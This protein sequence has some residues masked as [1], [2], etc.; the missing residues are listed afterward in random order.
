M[1]MCR[2]YLYIK[3]PYLSI[4]YACFRSPHHYH[5]RQN[6]HVHIRCCYIL[7]FILS[8]EVER[9]KNMDKYKVSMVVTGLYLESVLRAYF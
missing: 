4:Y 2:V 1:S 8:G 9:D 7:S 6:T 5:H 3:R